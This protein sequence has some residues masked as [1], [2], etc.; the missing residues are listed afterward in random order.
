MKWSLHPV[1]MMR[2][3]STE[4]EWRDPEVSTPQRQESKL[5]PIDDRVPT[6]A[7]NRLRVIDLPE[8]VTA[9]Q[10]SAKFSEYGE[11]T[12]LYEPSVGDDPE[13]YTGK[14]RAFLTFRHG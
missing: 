6:H 2:Q 8:G 9:E 5:G 11:L 12:D 7:T 10:I 3:F 14:K 4:G 13:H 1:V